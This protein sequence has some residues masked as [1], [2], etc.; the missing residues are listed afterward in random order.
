[1]KREE[2]EAQ[3][4][5]LDADAITLRMKEMIEKKAEEKPSAFFEHSFHHIEAHMLQQHAWLF[6]WLRAVYQHT[7][8]EY[9]RI[10]KFDHK[11]GI[12]C[13]KSKPRTDA[14]KKEWLAF[15]NEQIKDQIGSDVEL[16][17]KERK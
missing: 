17:F 3:L 6:C 9:E 14:G 5:C 13:V 16:V 10:H 2:I 15:L 4:L 8:E 12:L 11:V 1:M 7:V